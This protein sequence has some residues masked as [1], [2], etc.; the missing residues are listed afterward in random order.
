MHS[1]DNHPW[2]ELA[3]AICAFVA[4]KP[5]ESRV[6][7]TPISPLDHEK[8]YCL[9]VASCMYND[10]VLRSLSKDDDIDFTSQIALKANYIAF[11]I[12]T[13]GMAVKKQLL[14]VLY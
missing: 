11:K 6:R 4:K 2:N 13:H 12:D 1:H 7:W 8:G 14:R 9:D 5:Q 10:F 3:D